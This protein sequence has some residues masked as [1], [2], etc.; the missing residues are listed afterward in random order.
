MFELNEAY[1]QTREY[2]DFAEAILKEET[3][4]TQY[5][6]DMII[7]IHKTNPY[8]YRQEKKLNRLSEELK[9][10]KQEI[11]LEINCVDIK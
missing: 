6:V 1:R 2:Q 9:M 3:N 10:K 8:L 7:L 11:P 4:L 5:L